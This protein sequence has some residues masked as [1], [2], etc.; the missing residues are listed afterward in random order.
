[1]NKIFNIDSPCRLSTTNRQLRI[2]LLESSEEHWIPI[3]DI[4]I[5]MISHPTSSVTLQTMKVMAEEGVGVSFCGSNYQPIS[6]CLPLE[7]HT[8]H[9]KRI[10]LQVGATEPLKKRAWQLSVTAKV[11]NQAGTLKHLKKNNRAIIR[12][13]S[14][15]MS[16]DKD[17]VE[18]KAARAYW[19]ELFSGQF[20]RERE[21]TWPNQPLNYLYA[22]VRSVV[23]RSIVGSGLVPSLGFHHSNQYN[24]FCLADD[25]IEPFRPIADEWVLTMNQNLD[26]TSDKES[27]DL[28]ATTRKYLQDLLKSRIVMQKKKYELSSAIDLSVDSYVRYLE[29]KSKTLLFP[30]W[31]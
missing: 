29:R 16:N 26:C 7:G 13:A 10:Q 15:V 23:C 9:S 25:L 21:G 8:L 17:N 4:S 30:T 31:Q 22:V 24:A 2:Q 1:M 6:L 20:K 18:A 19:K 14:E 11:K 28:S 27:G 5:L 12:Y 3:E